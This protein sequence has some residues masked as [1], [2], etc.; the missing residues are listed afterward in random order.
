MNPKKIIVF[1][2][3]GS[4]KSTFAKHYSTGLALPVL[5]LDILAWLPTSPP[6]RAPL[7]Q[8]FSQ[9]DAFIANNPGWVIE[10]CYADLLSKVA[11]EATEMFFLNP[12]VKICIENCRNRPWEPHKY[13]SK[14]AQDKNL[15]MLI[16]WV[17]KYPE[18]KDEFSLS[19]HQKLF[20]NF[21]GKKTELSSNESLQK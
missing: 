6:Q 1:G 20:N 18:R 8:G 19:A 11:N 3:S 15:S 21:N 12:S 5:D 13:A 17:C 16:D 4:G 9:I 14:Q 2:N 10:G 7:K